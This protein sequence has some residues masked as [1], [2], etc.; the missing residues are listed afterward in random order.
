MEK[1]I[2]KL[3]DRSILSIGGK[4]SQSFLQAIITCNVEK[5]SSNPGY[6]AILTPQGKL[7]Y[8]FIIFK[9]NN[10]FLLDISKLNIKDFKKLLT[11]YR[12]R[13]DISIEE[14][15][16]LSVFV[17]IENKTEDIKFLDPRLVEMGSRDILESESLDYGT[18]LI[19]YKNQKI[20]LGIAE[21]G[22]DL[23]AG[24][25][26]PM[27]ANL[28]YLKGID[29][30]KGC[31]I[32]QEVSSRMFRKGTAKKRIVSFTSNDDFTNKEEIV[33]NGTR[34]GT[35]IKKID[36]N[37]IALIKVDKISN[38]DRETAIITT[39]NNQKTMV[40]NLPSF[41]PKQTGATQK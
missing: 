26:F 21:T 40:I 18:D 35:V 20:K 37:G 5:M 4:D 12:L 22:D 19:L 39:E 36:A 8:D 15:F 10:E 41:F 13:S 11:I 16:D 34:I 30:Q 32:G 14:K 33:Y 27:E 23:D 6:G 7:L 2:I 1:R 3:S 31:F 9:K 29:F 38:P 17:D 28:D 25:I 24:E